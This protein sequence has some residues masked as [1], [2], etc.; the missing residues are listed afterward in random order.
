MTVE[1]QG[2]TLNPCRSPKEVQ[3]STVCDSE[4]IP[5]LVEERGNWIELT[6]TSGMMG[7]WLGLIPA[8]QDRRNKSAF[9]SDPDDN[10]CV[11]SP[12]IWE[13]PCAIR[14]SIISLRPAH[15]AV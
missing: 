14:L 4:D 6:G 10:A 8:S 7:C 12:A 11:W 5:S 2:G 3:E 1:S 13:Y 15:L 9:L